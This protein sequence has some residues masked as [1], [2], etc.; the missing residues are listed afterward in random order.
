MH[1]LKAKVAAM[2]EAFVRGDVPAILAALAPDVRWDHWPANAGQQAGVPWLQARTGPNEV[3]GFFQL[4]GTYQFKEFTVT[5]IV[6]GDDRVVGQVICEFTLPNG[7][8]VRDEEMHLFVFNAAGQVQ[9]FRHYCDT[10]KAVAILG[11]QRRAA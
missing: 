4:M 1:D 6:A 2:Y 11:N 9:A 10:A 8:T 3:L 5:S 7:A